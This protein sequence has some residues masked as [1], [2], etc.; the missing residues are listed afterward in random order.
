M[1]SFFYVA[2]LADSYPK[3]E[4][5]FLIQKKKGETNKVKGL[6]RSV[7]M[8]AALIG[9]GLG[10]GVQ[11]EAAQPAAK[12]LNPNKILNI[13]HRGASGHAPEHTLSAY[14]LGQRM[15][16][17]Y[18]EIDLQMTK[19]GRLIAMHDETLDR[20]TNGTGPVKDHTLKEI[21]KLD[22][23]SWF[24]KKYP[25]SAKDEYAGLKVPTLE[26]VIQ[27]FGRNARYYI[28]TKSPEVYPKMEEKLL[29]ILK[30][31]KLTGPSVHSNKVIIQSFSTES[32]KIIHRLDPGI[33]L[34]QLLWYDGPAAV[35]DDELEAY[36]SYS[37]GLGMNFDQIDRAYV[38]KVRKH[39]L[40][41]HPYTVNEKEDMQRLFDWGVTG[42]FTNFPDRLHEVLNENK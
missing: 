36:Q 1:G 14:E 26:E 4:S 9:T 12:P 28:E 33:P 11:A 23:G 38:Q 15:K 22:A 24:N 29:Q 31:Y 37:V 32:L 3:G 39:G 6:L 19:D 18:I 34:V 7:F 42:M 20:T 41:V 35:S 5:E 21:K 25:E 2:L 17:D 10:A 8:C 30:K 13:A 16:G 40:L 27:K